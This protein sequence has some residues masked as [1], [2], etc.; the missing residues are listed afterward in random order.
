[1]KTGSSQETG[2]RYPQWLQTEPQSVCSAS[3]VA[4]GWGRRSLPTGRGLWPPSDPYWMVSP[5]CGIIWASSFRDILRVL[6]LPVNP[7]GICVFIPVPPPL[8]SRVIT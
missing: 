5:T 4:R 6:H 3:S 8:A 2:L 7:D 1:M